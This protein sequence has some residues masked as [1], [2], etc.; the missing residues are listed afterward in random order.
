MKLG[1]IWEPGT[2]N[3]I[4]RVLIPLRALEQ[5]GHE[6]VWPPGEE[7]SAPLRELLHCDL[8]HCSRS[9]KQFGYLERLS[10]HGVAI[11]FDND[12]DFSGLDVSSEDGKLVKGLRGRMDNV[13]KARAVAKSVRI[14]DLATAPSE[15]LAE[16]YRTLGASHVAMIE[17]HLDAGTVGFG[18][19]GKHNGLVVGWIAAYEH[20]FDLDALPIVD[21][22]GR[23]LDRHAKLRVLSVGIELPLRHER[24]EHREWVPYGDL[25]RVTGNIDIAIA[26][27][28]DTRF[29]RARSNIKLK[30]YASGG[31]PWLASPVGPYRDLGESEGGRLVDDDGWF[32]ALDELISSRRQRKRLARRALRWAGAQT[33]DRLAHLWESELEGAIARAASRVRRPV[34]A[35]AR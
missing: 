26:P 22:L 32:G 13:A 30:E 20:S 25:L 1:V 17:N 34:A 6:V 3:S 21:V 14:A 28:A 24:Y 31:A 7:P 16:Q 5:R 10:R 27:L 11:S 8:V 29:N 19:R 9:F 15:A 2:A 18:Y 35:R 23:L 4:Y 12:D 33:I